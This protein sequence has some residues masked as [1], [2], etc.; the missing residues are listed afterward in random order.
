MENLNDIRK[1]RLVFDARIARR[2]CKR[3]L[4]IIDIKPL[5]TDKEKTVFIFENT[6]EF[7]NAFSEITAEFAS[8]SEAKE[9]IE[10]AN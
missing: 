1:T 9:S 10:T 7:K 5:H 4:H 3:G 2:L 6:E 8:K